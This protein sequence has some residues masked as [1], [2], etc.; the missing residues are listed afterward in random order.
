MSQIGPHATHASFK[1]GALKNDETITAHQ[2]RLVRQRLSIWRRSH[3]RCVLC[4][5]ENVEQTPTICTHTFATSI[6]SS[7]GSAQPSHSS[8]PHGSFCTCRGLFSGE[9]MHLEIQATTHK[10]RPSPVVGMALRFRQRTLNAH[11]P[12]RPG[13]VT[14]SG[15]LMLPLIFSS[16]SS[17]VKKQITH[18]SLRFHDKT[19]PLVRAMFF[20]VAL[21]LI[22]RQE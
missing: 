18:K 20:K 3:R 4:K 9:K 17:S 6:G 8:L 2:E 22:G 21:H 7:H 16:F 14:S 1:F 19:L 5:S 15:S 12:Q 11:M 13:I 10:H